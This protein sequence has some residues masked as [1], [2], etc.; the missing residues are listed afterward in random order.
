[1]IHRSLS[2]IRTK[3]ILGSLSGMAFAC[4]LAQA[5]QSEVSAPAVPRVPSVPLVSGACPAVHQGGAISLD[6]NPGFDPFW[7]GTGMRSF[8]L[9]FHQLKE[10]GVT[11]N[12]ASRLVLDSG[13]RSRMTD[14]GNGYIH[15]EARL[16]PM[17][18]RGTYHLVGAVG[19]PQLLPD[20]QGEAPRMTVSPVRESYCITVV[21]RAQTP[22]P[23]S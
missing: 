13:P 9:I 8:R 12:P 4:A 14:I 2:S 7:A 5:P 10:D 22:S 17:A 11:L 19:S 1:M 16:S 20:Y 15:I 23:S 21:P 3:A 6:W 18:H